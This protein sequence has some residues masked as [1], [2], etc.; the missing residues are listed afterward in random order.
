MSTKPKKFMVLFHISHIS[1][2]LGTGC[3]FEF[4]Y[5]PQKSSLIS[6][7]VERNM[8]VCSKNF[9]KWKTNQF[10]ADDQVFSHLANYT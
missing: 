9:K 5:M 2:G 7:T 1:H 6:V 8:P 4:G 10:L 3:F